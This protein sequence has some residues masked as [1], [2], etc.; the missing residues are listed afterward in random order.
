MTKQFLIIAHRGESFDA[1]ENTLASINLAWERND[2]AVE[3]DIQLSK[4]KKIVVIHDKNTYR[5]TGKF[6]KILAQTLK[7]LQL[8][9]VG[10]HKGKKWKG[11]Y[12]PTLREVLKT[13]PQNKYLFIEIKS[14]S[15]IIQYLKDI[16]NHSLIDPKFIKFIAFNKN[17]LS[18]LKTEFPKY[19]CYWIYKRILFFKRINILKIIGQC[20]DAGLNGL[21]LRADTLNNESEARQIKNAGLDLYTWTINTFNETKKF[22][23]WGFDGVTSD[24]ASWLQDKF[25]R[26]YKK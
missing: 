4:D 1:P 11:E 18:K 6:K 9:D 15:E 16:L 20:K 26:Y 13:L 21:D 24:K 19:D 10:K 5:L 25:Q 17:T 7:Y 12:I 23:E 3:I 8:L 2:N 22:Y 14:S